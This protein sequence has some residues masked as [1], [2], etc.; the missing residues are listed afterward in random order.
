M[1]ER[2]SISK[3]QNVYNIFINPFKQLESKRKIQIAQLKPYQRKKKNKH[4]KTNLEKIMYKNLKE[5]KMYN[6]FTEK[7]KFIVEM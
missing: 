1:S 4:K 6:S 5:K 7:L 2:V 3:M